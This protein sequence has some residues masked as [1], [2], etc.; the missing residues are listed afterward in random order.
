MAPSR[1]IADVIVGR[2]DLEDQQPAIQS[3]CRL[4]IYN[5]AC[6]ILDLE[7][8]IERR[9]AIANLPAKLKPHVEK[10]IMRVWEMRK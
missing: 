4:E 5:R 1:L 10:E 3:A 8:K 2:T 7:T 6:M 9:S